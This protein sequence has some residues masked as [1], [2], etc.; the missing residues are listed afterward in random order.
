MVQGL[1]VVNGCHIMWSLH[2]FALKGA[3]SSC[4]SWYTLLH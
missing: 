1:V 3:L 4:L 2:A